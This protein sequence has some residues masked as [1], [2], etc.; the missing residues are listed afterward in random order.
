MD[1]PTKTVTME[2]T[3]AKN[4]EMRPVEQPARVEPMSIDNVNMRGGDEGE[5]VCCGLCAAFACFECCKC[6][7]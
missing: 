6:C 5:E 7:C 3:A 2:P 4:A 1:A